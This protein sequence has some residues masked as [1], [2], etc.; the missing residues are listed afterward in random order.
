MAELDELWQVSFISGA[1][2][3]GSMKIL[4]NVSSKR[5][6]VL[7]VAAGL[8]VFA[9]GAMNAVTLPEGEDG[10][11]RFD[12]VL[13][14]H[15]DSNIEGV[16]DGE[17]DVEM[18]YSPTVG[19]TSQSG[20][21]GLDARVGGVFGFFAD[22]S[23][24][25]YQLIRSNVAVTYPNTPDIPYTLTLSGGYNETSDVD[26]FSGRRLE[27]GVAAASASFRYNVNERWGFRVSGR[28]SD[29]DYDDSRFS[30]QTTKGGGLDLVY[31]YSEK[32][33]VFL[34][35]SYSDMDAS[36]DAEDHTFRLSLE[37]DIT[38]K[39]TGTLGFGYQI[40]ETEF[41]ES[42]DPYVNLSLGWAV[43]ERF[44]L[45]ASGNMGFF[46]TSAGSSGQRMSAGLAGVLALG[47]AVSASLGVN[48]QE[49]SYDTFGLD[50]DDEFLAYRAGILWQLG[51]SASL[52]ASITYSDVDSTVD[53][54]VYDRLRAGLGFTYSF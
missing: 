13:T 27:Y 49:Q 5:I 26:T 31:I 28:W 7:W 43:N 12:N 22:Q 45:V 4:F 54:L 10:G 50:R 18:T 14:A 52:E 21:L 44:E 3:G 33:D 29:L 36:T 35:Y 53:R 11:L 24:Y 17:S 16:K 8:A 41:D 51:L 37:G 48:W 15:Y 19:F 23:E 34:G 46:T 2:N 1:T 25:D 9:G 20:L 30:S 6:P 38:P 32:L 42:G 47:G 40:R 39:L